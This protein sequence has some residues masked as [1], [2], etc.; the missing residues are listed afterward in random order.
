M[1]KLAALVD[2]FRLS[3]VDD[4]L[5]YIH[6]DGVQISSLGVRARQAK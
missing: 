2:V 3:A 1:K 4:A 6:S 5:N